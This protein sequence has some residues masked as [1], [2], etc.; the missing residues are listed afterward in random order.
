M[1]SALDNPV[2]M[3]GFISIMGVL[4][5]ILGTGVVVALGLGVPVK[6]SPVPLPVRRKR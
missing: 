2:F 6:M 4:A 5:L 3:N 1:L